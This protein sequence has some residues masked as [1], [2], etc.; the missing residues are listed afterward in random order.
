MKY[1]S[2]KGMD[3]ILPDKIKAVQDI[4]GIARS[5]LESFGYREVRT[6]ILEKTELFVRGI[7]EETDIV[8]KE[9]YTFNDRKGRSLTMRPEGT[10]PIIRAYVEH[11]IYSNT[12]ESRL[13]YIGPMFRAERPQKGRS[14]QFHQIG[15]EVIGLKT[16]YADAEV[17]MQISCLLKDFGLKGFILKINS[18]GCKK[19]KSRFQD[20]LRT[21]LKDR[22]NHL[23]EDCRLRVKKNVL[24]VLDCKKDTCKRVLGSAPDIRDCF[25]ESCRNDY[26]Q[27]KELLKGLKVEFQ[28]VKNLV[29]G[30]DYYTGTVFEITHPALGGQDALAAGGRYDNLVKE[31]GGPDIG[32]VGYAIGIERVL[33]ALD[34]SLEKKRSIFIATLGH[35]AKLKGLGL[36]QELRRNV[37]IPVISDIGNGSLKSQLR[38]ASRNNA[39]VSLIIGDDELKK[40]SVVVRDMTRNQQSEVSEKD[41]VVKVSAM[42]S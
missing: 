7:G 10:A 8:K 38:A 22:E 24:R 36:A 26:T 32:A 3:D 16:P 30:L 27:I 35:K 11:S 5:Q 13:Y 42:I 9:M 1:Q 21:Y 12:P 15:V 41:V 2:I 18:L 17:I 31:M 23:C 28:E 14:R 34:R 40:K 33:I 29:R 4:E 37:K 19:D 39:C 20:A 6:P 25:C